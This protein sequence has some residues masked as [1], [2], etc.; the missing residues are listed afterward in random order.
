MFSQPTSGLMIHSWSFVQL[1][2]NADQKLTWT[3]SVWDAPADPV[4]LYLEALEIAAID[5]FGDF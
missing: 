2:L 5:I 1:S 4:R 3:W